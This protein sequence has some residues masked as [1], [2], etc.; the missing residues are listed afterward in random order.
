M[1]VL[2]KTTKTIAEAI[3]ENAA[4]AR[5]AGRWLTFWTQDGQTLHTQGP[6][7]RHSTSMEFDDHDGVHHLIP[8][9]SVVHV[10]VGT[11]RAHEGPDPPG[12]ECDG[13]QNAADRCSVACIRCVIRSPAD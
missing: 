12:C 1:V 7:T 4:A 6:L 3:E 5:A 8:L 2:I 10:Q 9:A 11:A 13:D